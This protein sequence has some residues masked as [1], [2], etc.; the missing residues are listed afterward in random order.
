MKLK[1]RVQGDIIQENKSYLPVPS[2]HTATSYEIS[3]N[4]KVKK[5]SFHGDVTIFFSK[6]PL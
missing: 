3:R 4:E 2:H 1:T 5:K 6:L